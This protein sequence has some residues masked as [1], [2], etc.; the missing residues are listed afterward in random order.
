MNKTE[1]KLAEDIRN[2]R[3]SLKITQKEMG[4][5]L[6]MTESSYNRIESGN[7]AI[8]YAHLLSISSVFKM[9]IIDILSYPASPQHACAE[10]KIV[11]SAKITLELEVSDDNVVKMRL[12][13]KV[14]QLAN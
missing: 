12:K 6:N 1:K 4:E 13:D 5:Q 2:I 10:C 9:S 3:R 8:S 14:I 11:N 7:I